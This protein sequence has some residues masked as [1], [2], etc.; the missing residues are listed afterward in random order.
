M[1]LFPRFVAILAAA[2][3]SGLAQ[4]PQ[5]VMQSFD[6]A[7]I[8]PAK[9]G[10]RG[11]S[12][13]PLPGRVSAQNVTL[14][15]LIAEAYH[16][17]DFQISGGPKWLDDDRYDV[18]AKAAGEA[19]P[20]KNQLRAML[21]S[22]LADRFS[23]TIHHDTKEMQVFALE[24]AK[25]GTKAQ[26]AKHPDSPVMFRVFQR[27]QI[28]AENAPLDYLTEALTWLLGRPVL[29]QSGL[30]GS[31]DYKLE[32]APD[33]LQIQA[34]EAPPQTDGSA[35]SLSAALQQQMGLRLVSKKDAVD[36]IAVDKAE[37]PTAN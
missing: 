22:L 18:E 33:E 3:A 21:R 24:A 10:T 27:R 31:F 16:V 34:Q 25:G 2:A 23:L 5:P 12:I 9:P 29:D 30:E 20:N 36:L 15:L 6:A 13:Q 4:T 11:Y 17:Y 19:T 7:S 32:W 1:H 35:P 37:R 26:P 28:T 14:K 8:K